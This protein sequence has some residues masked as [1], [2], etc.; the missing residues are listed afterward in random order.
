MT[1]T[2]LDI[3]LKNFL[4]GEKRIGSIVLNGSSG[5]TLKKFNIENR[6]KKKL[7]RKSLLIEN[8]NYD[9]FTSEEYITSIQK[10]LK[11]D[12]W[13]NILIRER[14]LPFNIKKNLMKR[15]AR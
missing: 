15:Y 5:T 7:K 6:Y 9:S 13:K 10:G 2:V 4:F 11:K 1:L 14:N 12:L 8:N 3:V